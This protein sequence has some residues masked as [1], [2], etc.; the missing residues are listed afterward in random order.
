MSGNATVVGAIE[1]VA[2]ITSL[3]EKMLK[4]PDD[5]PLGW[6][7]RP[8]GPIQLAVTTRPRG[9]KI[10]VALSGELDVLTAPRL[11]TRL[12]EVVRRHD[13]DVVVDLSATDFIDSLGL[14]AL[15][16]FQR[17]LM[18]QSRSMV[19]VCPNGPV[20]RAIELA[21]LTEAL[22]V[23]SSAADDEARGANVA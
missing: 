15:L 5:P 4:S 19:V 3:E 22:G 13:A 17:R 7:L 11:T 12:D 16:S 1:P 14:H 18:R 23:V 10:V 2:P 21:R 6:S 9:E 20:H 8:W